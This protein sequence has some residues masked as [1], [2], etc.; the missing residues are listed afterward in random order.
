LFVHPTGGG[1]GSTLL[2]QTGLNWTLGAVF[3]DTAAP[4]QLLQ[5]GFVQRFPNVRVIFSHLGGT[6]PLLME[7]LDHMAER[8]MAGRGRPSE[9]L[10][11]FWYDTANGDPAALRCACETLGVDRL[12][13]GVDYPYLRGEK[14]RHGY[15]YIASTGLTAPEQHAIRAG[16][17]ATVLGRYARSIA[18]A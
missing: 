7:R 14:Y 2:V 11:K 10:K 1:C 12:L 16:N 8:F 17:A 18:R 4:L 9:E 5:T 13:F 6:L 3:E 15:D